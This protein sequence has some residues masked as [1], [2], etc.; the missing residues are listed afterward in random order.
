MTMLSY[1]EALAG[2]GALVQSVE[3]ALFWGPYWTRQIQLGSTTVDARSTNTNELQRGLVLGR[4]DA[5]GVYTH[6]LPTATDGTE[7]ARVILARAVNMK[8]STGTAVNRLGLAA[9]WGHVIAG[10]CGG[11]TT[12][13]R[14]HLYG[15]IIFDD[16]PAPPMTPFRLA[17][18]KTAD[19]TITIA[20]R[21]KIF[22]NGGAT[23]A[24]NFTLPAITAGFWCEIFADADQTITVTSATA[25]TLIVYNDRAADSV[26]LS[27]SSEKMGGAFR[28]VAN[29]DASRWMVFPMLWE[30]QTP[31][32]AT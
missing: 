25:D 22:T 3:E 18:A 29:A 6:S 21:G 9:G 8:D 28:I 27:T 7:I 15:T 16:D 31:V 20:D 13:A 4:K 11:L 24:V 10:D 12:L 30:A 5:D 23:G 2:V 1:P 26:A 17:Y 14:A 32:V 19:Y